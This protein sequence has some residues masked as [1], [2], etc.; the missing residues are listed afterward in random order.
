MLTELYKQVVL[1]IG[2]ALVLLEYLLTFYL[3]YV[4]SVQPCVYKYLFDALS[5][6]LVASER[7]SVPLTREDFRA[8]SKAIAVR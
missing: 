5:C 1:L 4:Y 8:P 2:S 3:S 7:L 6:L